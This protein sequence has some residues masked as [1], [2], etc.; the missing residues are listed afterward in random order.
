M[1]PICERIGV[2]LKNNNV[3]TAALTDTDWWALEAFVHLVRLWASAD[4][5]REVLLAAA[6][7][8]RQMQ[9]HTR[10]VAKRAIPCALDWGHENELWPYIEAK[11]RTLE[12]DGA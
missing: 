9:E 6:V 2:W 12:Q 7:C 1:K 5:P 4:R 10:H 11:V 8:V 3:S